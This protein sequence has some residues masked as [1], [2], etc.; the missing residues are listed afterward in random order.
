[1]Q[2]DIF[3]R[4][5]VL[6]PNISGLGQREPGRAMPD[7]PVALFPGGASRSNSLAST[8]SS[9]GTSLS[10]R[11]R[12]RK[13]TRT[14][15]A[16][17]TG[18]TTGTTS[19]T[20]TAARGEGLVLDFEDTVLDISPSFSL[21]LSAVSA[22]GPSEGALADASADVSHDGDVAGADPNTSIGTRGTFGPVGKDEAV[23]LTPNIPREPEKRADLPATT[24]A[25]HV[26]LCWSSQKP[27]ESL[28][29]AAKGQNATFESPSLD[30]TPIFFST[31]PCR[32]RRHQK[33]RAGFFTY[34]A[35][36]DLFFGLSPQHLYRNR[37]ASVPSL[38][39]R[40]GTSHYAHPCL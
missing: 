9:G 17:N 13:R 21:E 10:R 29:Q 36:L 31:N 8:V 30:L 20:G 28:N 32:R 12:I 22:D 18:P 38:P 3:G 26:S 40:T 35:V 19:S 25:S 5:W 14:A 4:V 6:L 1:M 24:F 15:T 7:S 2:A 16:D 39:G 11:S 34:T 37:I 33:Q 27:R 23:V